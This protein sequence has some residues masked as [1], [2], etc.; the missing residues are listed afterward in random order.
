MAILRAMDGTFYEIP[1]DQVERY[2]IPAD[3]LKEKIGEQ[4]S[5]EGPPP[6]GPPES[7]GPSSPLVNV[8]IFYGG[9]GGGA[10][11][12]A[13]GAVQPY[14]W[15]NWRNWSNWNNWRNHWRNRFD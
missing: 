12:A 10:P 4:A 6:G 9:Q 8:H 5:A 1:D 3:K 11:A 15:R 13:E 7:G 2:K 14:D